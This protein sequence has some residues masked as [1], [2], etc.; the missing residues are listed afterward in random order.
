MSFSLKRVGR[1]T[2]IYGAGILLNRAVAFLMLPI[3]TRFLTPSQFGVLE[4][5]G[6]A[7]EVL[8][9][10]AGQR[11]GEGIYYYYH[12]AESKAEK[13]AVVSTALM[14]IALAYVFVTVPALLFAPTLSMWIFQTAGYENLFRIGVAG[15]AFSALVLVP[16]TY[17]RVRER[18]ILYVSVSGLKLF[19]QLSLNVV[20][21]IMLRRGAE[22]V[23]LSTLIA[24]TIIGTGLA[25]YV[26]RQAG[27]MFSVPI[28]RRLLRFGIPLIG[29]QIATFIATF[30]DRYFLQHSGGTAEVGIY[31]LAYRFGFLLVAVGYAPFNMVWEPIRFEISRR[32]DRDQIYARTFVYFNI[33]LFTTAV[34]IALFVQDVIRIMAEPAFHRAWGLVPLLLVA[35]ILQSWTGFHNIGVLVRERTELIALANWIGAAAALLCYW[36]LIPPYLGWGAAIGTVVGFAVRQALIYRFA[37]RLWPVKYHWPPVLRLSVLSVLICLL[38][39]PAASLS[40]VGS[41]IIRSLLLVAYVAGVWF[42]GIL[43]REG[44]RAALKIARS[45]RRALVS[46]FGGA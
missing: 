5:V 28:A 2:M 3:Y 37:Q 27:T 44:R 26:L 36:K 1:H 32:A 4:L 41:L 16:F 8:S 7:L 40:I 43:P 33:L 23:L 15:F 11:V 25:L 13:D 10:A 18:S 35:Y 38:S 29:T 14:L 24:N 46:L 42:L 6:M 34:G 39:L 20:F 9:I 22:G 45:P 19:V 12:R 31:G 17:L 21:V 30:S